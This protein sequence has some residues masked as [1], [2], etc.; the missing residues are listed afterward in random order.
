MNRLYFLVL[1]VLSSV[2]LTAQPR[3]NRP[4]KENVFERKWNFLSSEA[5][6]NSFD[7]T[8]VHPLFLEYEEQIWEL[9]AGNRE[10]FRMQRRQQPQQKVDFEAINDA[11]IETELTKARLQKE[12]YLKLKK[13]LDAETINKLFH[14]EKAYQ[15]ELIQR[16]PDRMPKVE[17]QGQAR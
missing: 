3:P 10:I 12:Y 11:M 16:I 13:L 9:Y 4:S 6:L 7:E 2:T 15:R 17:R 8:R 5:G 14:A 1:L